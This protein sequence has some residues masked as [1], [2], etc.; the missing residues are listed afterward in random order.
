V[1]EGAAEGWRP[2]DWTLN[3][4]PV[5]GD[6]RQHLW[7]EKSYRDFVFICDWRWTGKPE[8]RALPVLAPSGEIATDDNGNPV[9]KQ[10]SDAGEC[11][12]YLRGDT[13]S[14]I[15]LSCSPSGSGEIYGY[16]TDREAP[17][18]IR[19]GATPK[20]RADFEPGRWNRLIVTMRGDRASVNVNGETVVENAHLPGL[21]SQ[22]PL[23]LRHT[24]AEIQ[25]AGI[26]VKD[27]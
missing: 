4:G 21:P 1:Q 16:R 24:G 18:E 8:S 5:S 26:Y 14:E 12:V 3:S 13:K 7:T 20:L 25:F 2:N 19:A 9:T 23:G 17:A 22:G 15:R 27:L 11:G 6:G 10:V